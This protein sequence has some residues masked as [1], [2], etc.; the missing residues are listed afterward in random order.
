MEPNEVVA[1]FIGFWFFGMLFYYF[2]YYIGVVSERRR[3]IINTIRG[4]R[5]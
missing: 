5:T 2:G 1:V 4:R 3:N